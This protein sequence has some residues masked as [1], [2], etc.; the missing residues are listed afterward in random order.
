[1][2]GKS[3]NLKVNVTADTSSF[4]KGMQKA[5]SELSE[6]QKVATAPFRTA[7]TAAAAFAAAVAGVAKAVS[8]LS[9]QNQKLG[10]SW[11]RLT[12][13][14][15]ASWDAFKTA[16][17]NTSFSGVLADMREA[18]RLAR[19]LYDARDAMGEIETA[20]N[21]AL[22]R[23]AP[24]INDLTLKLRDAT[25]SEKERVRAGEELLRVYEELEKNPT[26]GLLNVSDAALD[27]IAGK[28]GYRLKGA[29]EEALAATRREVEDFFVWLGTE[30]GEAWSSAFAAAASDPTKLMQT[31]IDA[32]NAGLSDNMRALLFNYQTKV[33]DKDRVAMEEAVTAY[34]NQQAKYSSETLR[35]QTQIS[36]LRASETK[37]AGK[38]QK[39]PLKAIKEE[40][41]AAAAELAEVTAADEAMVQAGNEAYEAWRR[42]NNMETQPFSNDEL[43]MYAKTLQDVVNYEAQIVDETE[44]LQGALDRLQDKINGTLSRSEE[45]ATVFSEEL[46]KSIEN[47]LVG[48]FDALAEAI[49]GVEQGGFSSV[50][51]AL[52]D[53]LADMAIRV[54]TLIMMSGAAIDALKESLI[55]FF[56]GSA[57]LAGG[58]LVAVGVAAKAGLASMANGSY[59]APASVAS[60]AYNTGGNDF[61]T[62]DLTVQVTGKLVAD[63]DQLTAVINNTNNRNGYTT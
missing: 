8:A 32:Q 38:G 9:E 60:G 13:G 20:Y 17:A 40:A 25:L 28:L 12:A 7:A 39:D 50:I 18:N 22:A 52:V 54:G 2:A 26:R 10:D 51:K 58:A 62:R 33:G 21:I 45:L 19:D 46:V 59:S 43:M 4:D 31:N 49:S 61:E 41:R 30:A 37:S 44:L 15:T 48:A 23:Q 5:K 1:M 34:Y 6:F 42:L 56:G 47:G 36:S 11:G 24:L 27:Q 29:S 3:P 55:G 16:V 57:I 53:P 63:G 14:M 35:I